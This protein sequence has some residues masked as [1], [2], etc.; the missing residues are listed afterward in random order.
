[1]GYRNLNRDETFILP[2]SKEDGDNKQ[3]DI[4][5]INEE[6]VFIIEC[7]SSLK[8]RKAPSYKDEFDLLK[9]RLE[10]FRKAVFQLFG[11][12]KKIKYIF[13]THNIRLGS[14][15]DD[16][17]RLEKVYA[18][19]YNNNTYDYVNNLIKNYKKAS[20]YQFLGLIFKNERINRN[21]IEIPA[22]E[23]SMGS[24]NKKYYMFS[25]EP[26]LLLKLGFI[27][28]RTKAN[29]NEM[30]TYQ[31]LLNP[32]RLTGIKNFINE[33]GY[34]PNSLIVNFNST[35]KIIFEPSSRN[36][37]SSSRIGTL[38]I[39]NEYA[40]AYI[41]DGQHRLYGYANSKFI[42]TNTIPVVALQGLDSVEQLGIFM[43][44]NQNQKAV[45]ASLRGV[46]E[47]DLYWDH[48]HAFRRLQALRSSIVKQLSIGSGPLYNKIAIGEDPSLLTF[49]PFS[50]AL[51]KSGLLPTARGDKYDD[52]TTITSLYNTNNSN[53]NDEM[54]KSK[55]KITSF[56]NF[57]Y[58]YI[59]DNYLHIFEDD[60]YFIVSNR[61]TI[62]F[63]Y[64]TPR[65][66][67]SFL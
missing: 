37:S 16:M 43:D 8:E 65:K 12:D 58:G 21:I 4:I 11:K 44:I 25:I 19:Y 42:D 35:K 14:D 39:P 23:G 30:P 50:D 18:F 41:I 13:A 64:N 59:E 29:E 32:K 46:L 62:P 7:K 56:I 15:S 9:L 49:K 27:L 40:I 45:S 1:M 28:H 48:E 5:A 26:S 33:G 17:K 2:F 34:F 3:I 31:R 60:K 67:E 36:T 54:T 24:K 38:K 53:H 52:K 66:Q 51:S 10:G 47:D 6:T 57:C 22:I 55:K 61:G 63:I 20:H